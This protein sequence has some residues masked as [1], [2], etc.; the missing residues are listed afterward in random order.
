MLAG[1][2]ASCCE[3]TWETGD[4]FSASSFSLQ[5]GRSEL[6][7]R[8]S[9]SAFRT[10]RRFRRA[11]TGSFFQGSA[12]G[13]SA[14]VP[15]ATA[16]DGEVWSACEALLGVFVSLTGLTTSTWVLPIVARLLPSHSMWRASP[17][18]PIKLPPG[19][20]GFPSAGALLLLLPELP[21]LWRAWAAL[22]P[23]PATEW[24]GATPRPARRRVSANSCFILASSCCSALTSWH[25]ASYCFASQSFSCFSRSTTLASHCTPPSTTST[26]AVEAEEEIAAEPW[27]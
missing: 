25:F 9:N 13:F 14:S 12:F 11:E 21:L 7:G 5:P 20:V 23:D 6:G 10:D 3:V 27:A 24:D 4:S 17:R 15:L 19:E 1:G 18:L 26:T 8:G 22:L 2:G 16:D